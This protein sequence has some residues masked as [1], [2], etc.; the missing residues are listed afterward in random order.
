MK[1]IWLIVVLLVAVAGGA[2]AQGMPTKDQLPPG[3]WHQISPGGD[4]IC[5]HGAPY[6]FYYRDNPGQDLLIN[7]QGGGMCWNAQTCN[8]STTT[9]DDS[10]NPGDPSDNPALFPVGMTDFSTPDNPFINYDMVYVNY[11]TGD[12]HTGNANPGYDF[13]GTWFDVKHKGYI[14]ASTV[15]NWVYSNLPVV[16]SVFVAGCSAGAVGAA[17]WSADIKA[18]YPNTRVTL[19]GDSG[20]GWRG[21]PGSTFDLWGTSYQGATG[22]NLSIPRFYAGAAQLGVRTA[23]YNTAYDETQSFFNFVGFSSVGYGDALRANLR[24]LARSG[25][26]FRSYTAGGSLHCILPRAEFY[27]YS[28]NGVRFRDWIAAL[29]AGQGAQNVACTDCAD[30]EFYTPQ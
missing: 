13:E 18:H 8:I 16:D 3:Q 24:D 23:A 6:S 25:G 5:G 27:T 22:G 11:C 30:P 14:N 19:L 21:I 29:A 7:F 28:A 4:T 1:R 26:N 15:L 9:F 10:I 2:V 12:M 20:S 17:Y